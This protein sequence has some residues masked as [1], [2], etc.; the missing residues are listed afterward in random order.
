MRTIKAEIITVGDELLY[1]QILDTN[2]QW[3][4]AELDKIGVRVVRRTTVGDIAEDMLTAFKEAESRADIILITGGLGP[5]KDDLTKPL[6]AQ[7]F[8]C[9]MEMVPEALEEV[10]QYFEKRGRELTELNRQQAVLPTKCTYIP[11]KMGTAP[12]MWFYENGK[13]WMSMPGVP[14]EMKALMTDYVIPM[15]KETFDTPVIYHKTIK[16]VGIGESFLA[17]LISDWEDALPQ[18]IKLAYLPSPGLV[19]M[20]LTAQGTDEKL[21][22]KD[23]Q[24]QID[25]VWPLISKYAYGFDL[26][27]LEQHIGQR[28]MA[29]QETLA[30]AESCSGGYV[31]HMITSVPGSSAYFR[32]SILPYHNEHKIN[33]LKVAESTI[34]AHGAVSEE[35]VSEM[36]ARVRELFGTTYGIATSG[37]AGPDGGTAEKPVGTVWIAVA[38]GTQ[39]FAKKLMLTKDRM[40]NIQ[41]TG[42][43]VLNLL[44]QRLNNNLH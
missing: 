15:I 10:R 13:A 18:H 36:A 26:E 9:G 8:N 31:S 30:I 28:L 38:D 27:T 24:A 35:T 2:S 21:L 20:R 12:G 43:S 37:I 23:V 32:G 17:D 44:R 1:G 4:S 3:M 16:T 25:K 22:S 42:V 7:Y 41:L 40:L 11:N 34:A 6:L 19:R 29:N 5:T 33:Q 14:Y 39:T